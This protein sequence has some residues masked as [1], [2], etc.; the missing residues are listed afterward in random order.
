MTRGNWGDK[1]EVKD[2]FLGPDND[3]TWGTGTVKVGNFGFVSDNEGT[4]EW[5]VDEPGGIVAFTTDSGDDDN[6]ALF[7]GAF[8]PA[9]GKLVTEWRF[10]FNSATLSAVFVGF[11]ETLSLATPVMPA[12]FATATMTYNGTGGIVGAQFDADGD[13]DDFRAVGGDA[14]AASSNADTNGTRANETITADEWYIV[15]VELDEDGNATVYV[16]HKGD[17]L[18]A[19]ISAAGSNQGRSFNGAV[20]TPGDNFYAVC[21]FENRSAAARLF[22]VDYGIASGWTDWT[23]T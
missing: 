1:L 4:F 18:D 2:H 10:K 15:R 6:A 16:G 14:G 20:I 22:E 9:D 23:N 5:T 7:A 13:T 8:Q 12:E 21:M 11:S 17:H 19:I 3:L